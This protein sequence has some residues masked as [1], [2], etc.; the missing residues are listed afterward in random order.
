MY[1]P[2]FYNRSMM[3][4][5]DV[6]D[7]TQEYDCPSQGY[8]GVLETSPRLL[9]VQ[10]GTW[11]IY[12]ILLFYC[13]FLTRIFYLRVI[14]QFWS[15]LKWSRL[16]SSVYYKLTRSVSQEK[17][18]KSGWCR[19]SVTTEP[20]LKPVSLSPD[21]GDTTSTTAPPDPMVFWTEP[22]R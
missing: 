12:E 2:L 19:T 17:S 10:E 20:S 5:V 3:Y 13:K 6:Y 21:C 18:S 16:C 9:A 8:V 4:Y 7:P 11:I 15:N 22:P 1:T 14:P